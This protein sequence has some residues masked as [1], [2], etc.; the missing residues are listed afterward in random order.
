MWTLTGASNSA[1]ITDSIEGL[2]Q[3]EMS[4]PINGGTDV[5]F[6]GGSDLHGVAEAKIDGAYGNYSSNQGNFKDGVIIEK[7][8]GK[9]WS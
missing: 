1:Q 9:F 6:T 7:T 2:S 4:S 8:H 3:N 5:I